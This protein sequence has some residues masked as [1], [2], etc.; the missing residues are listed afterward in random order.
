MYIGCVASPPRQVAEG[1]TE[2]SQTRGHLIQD[3]QIQARVIYSQDNPPQKKIR[4][5]KIIL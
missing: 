3:N 1:Y 2:E 5:Y 4:N